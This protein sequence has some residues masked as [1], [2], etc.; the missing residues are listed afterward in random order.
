MTGNKAKR[1]A[2]GKGAA[3]DSDPMDVDSPNGDKKRKTEDTPSHLPD[4]ANVCPLVM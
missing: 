1:D 4:L 2:K 3:E